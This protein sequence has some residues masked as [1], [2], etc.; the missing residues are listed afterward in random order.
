MININEIILYY[1]TTLFYL[2]DVLCKLPLKKALLAY[3]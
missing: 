2:I 3:D 1:I